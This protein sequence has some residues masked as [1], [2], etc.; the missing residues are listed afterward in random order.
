MGA[1]RPVVLGPRGGPDEAQSN[2]MFDAFELFQMGL[3]SEGVREI[4][5]KTTRNQC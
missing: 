4:N 1:A 5:D 2:D 3:V